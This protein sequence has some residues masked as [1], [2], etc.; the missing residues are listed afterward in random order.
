VTEEVSR[1]GTNLAFEMV[2][3]TRAY[4]RD[5][6]AY[7][8]NWEGGVLATLDYGLRPEDI[9]DEDLRAAWVELRALHARMKPLIKGFEKRLKAP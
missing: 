1:A 8:V 2:A 4:D 5:L 6:L 3:A 7:K 9:A